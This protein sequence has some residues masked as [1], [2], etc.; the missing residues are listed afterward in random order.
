M[1]NNTQK[2]SQEALL[3]KQHT[4]TQPLLAITKK[5]IAKI[6]KKSRKVK[7]LIGLTGCNANQRN[8]ALRA[9]TNIN[10][11]TYLVHCSKGMSPKQFFKTLLT[12]MQLKYNSK[13]TVFEL[14]AKVVMELNH[15]K[16]APL[17][18][19]NNI[20]ELSNIALTYIQNISDYTDVGS[21]ILSGANH[22]RYKLQKNTKGIPELNNRISIWYEVLPTLKAK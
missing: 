8:E 15:H 4:Q 22:F 7:Q 20:D 11:N 14:M 21:I 5:D 19:I 18:L 13:K 6:C 2:Q 9:Y 17:I 3:A 10:K 1:Q 12:A 16:Q